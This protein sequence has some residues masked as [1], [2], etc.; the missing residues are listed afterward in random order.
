[1]G[2]GIVGIGN[3]TLESGVVV[4]NVQLAYE[5][6]GRQ[7]APTVLICHALTGN[8]NAVGTASHP[9]WW[10]GLV[11]QGK[12]ID[13]NRFSVITFNVLGGCEGSTGPLS[14]HSETGRPYRTSFPEVTIRDMVRA[15]RK[16]L[17]ALG[18]DRLH[19]IIGGSLGGMRVLEWGILFPDDVAV[20]I[21]IAVTP[22]LS[23]YGIAFN[24]IGLHAIENDSGFRNGNYVQPT[25]V[26]GFET[27]R[28]AGMVTYRSGKL[29]NDRF[30]R[31]E[32]KKGNYEIES[33]LHHI[34]K[35]IT[36]KFDPNSYCTLLR[37]MNTHDLGRGRG[38]IKEATRSIKA[39]VIAL[40]YTHDLIYPPEN[41][42][43]F[44]HLIPNSTYYLI[45]TEFGHDGFLT[46]YD[47]WGLIVK[48]YMEV[49][50]CRQSTSPYSASAL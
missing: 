3:L 32:S 47:K 5:K 16:A 18:V 46:E 37:A 49:T 4:E 42:Q 33:Y 9:G 29:F 11:G 22:A 15:E 45:N 48:Q 20:L 23:A 26:K 27:A 25:D 10:S 8:H 17:T 30:D 36:K 40:A 34:G 19:T 12:S 43:L 35:K 24:C 7:D 13:T 6:V 31:T 28:M 21:P 1:M 44:T 2:T 39:K 41:I 50:T 38:G 14:I